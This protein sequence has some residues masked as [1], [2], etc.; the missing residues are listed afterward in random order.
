MTNGR[1]VSIAM[2][3]HIE[4]PND[5]TEAT[6]GGLLSTM[7]EPIVNPEPGS[8]ARL[9]R[10]FRRI[11]CW[12]DNAI[13]FRIGMWTRRFDVPDTRRYAMM[14]LHEFAWAKYCGY[15][16]RHA[17]HMGMI[18]WR[19]SSNT[20]TEPRPQASAPVIGSVIVTARLMQDILVSH[21]LVDPCA[22]EDPEGYDNGVTL[23]RICMATYDLN[24]AISP[25]DQGEPRRG[26]TE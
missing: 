1:P 23:Q 22:V 11:D 3:T 7:T 13:W 26:E 4:K 21:G 20:G 12:M 17:W 8:L 19:P 24:D 18:Y 15:G 6:D 9:V 2:T 10:R 5:V 14:G 16:F 25:N